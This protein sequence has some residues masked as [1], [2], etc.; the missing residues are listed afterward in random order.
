MGARLD[1]KP[2]LK[3]TK[4]QESGPTFPRLESQKL[5]VGSHD[6]LGHPLG[7]SQGY[8]LESTAQTPFD[9]KG[10][11]ATHRCEAQCEGRGL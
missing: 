2:T 11:E 8:S 10:R 3:S 6:E 1:L 5:A 9:S 7:A 4:P